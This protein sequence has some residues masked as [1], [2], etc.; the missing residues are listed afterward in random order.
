MLVTNSNSA[1]LKDERDQKVKE[2][3]KMKDIP[4]HGANRT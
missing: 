4:F 3:K 1:G 2:G